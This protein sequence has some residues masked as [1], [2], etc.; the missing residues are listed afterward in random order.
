MTVIL[1][2]GLGQNMA[3][4]IYSAWSTVNSASRAVPGW[5]SSASITPTFSN[6]NRSVISN[7]GGVYITSTSFQTS[8]KRYFETTM[9]AAGTDAGVDQAGIGSSSAL[10]GNQLGNDPSGST[11]G[12][13]SGSGIYYVLYNKLLVYNSTITAV[14]GDVIGVA[15]DF[16]VA[17]TAAVYFRFNA[18]WGNGGTPQVAFPS[19]PDVQLPI[20]AAG[21]IIMANV[22]IQG[23]ATLNTGNAPFANPAP[24][25][26]T[27]WG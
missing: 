16:T 24:A 4:H 10:L 20:T 21:A 8:G 6:N 11:T 22:G 15:V 7:G 27:A 14:N 9:A 5:Y 17:G 3:P 13:Y 1:P 25:G 18:S 19:T 26:Y 12:S 2:G 23:T